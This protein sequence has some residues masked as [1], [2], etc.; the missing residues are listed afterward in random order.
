MKSK[1]FFIDSNIL[2]L[3]IKEF[4]NGSKEKKPL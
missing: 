3:C 2:S 4:E 1:D